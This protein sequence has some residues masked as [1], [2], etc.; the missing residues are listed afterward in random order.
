VGPASR[1]AAAPLHFDENQN[2][3][4]EGLVQL[5]IHIWWSEPRRTFDLDEVRDRKR[6]NELVLC[7]GDEGDVL[8]FVQFEELKVLWGELFLPRHVRGAW[9]AAYPQ[10]TVLR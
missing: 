5:P 1:P 6:V 4:A 2:S 3:K 10:R 7:E 8:H 9:E